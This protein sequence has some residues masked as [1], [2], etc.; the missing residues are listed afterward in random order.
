M[1]Y[2]VV[3]RSYRVHDLHARHVLLHTDYSHYGTTLRAGRP[4]NQVSITSKGKNCSF[5]KMPNSSLDFTEPTAQWVKVKVK[6]KCSRYRSGVVQ[7]VGEGIALLFHDSSPLPPGKTRY[8]FYI[9]LGGPQDQSGRAENL[10]AAGIRSRTIQPL[11][12]RYTD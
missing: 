11:V 4:W 2:K 3:T 6:V 1:E 10:V 9:W 8:P 12:S 5:W 7:R